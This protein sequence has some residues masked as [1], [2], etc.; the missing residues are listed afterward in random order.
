MV[1]LTLCAN[2]KKHHIAAPREETI[3]TNQLFARRSLSHRKQTNSAPPD[4][5]QRITPR[6]QS[7]PCSPARA[8]LPDARCWCKLD[9]D[10][11]GC[12]AAEKWLGP[13]V[14]NGQSSPS[15]SILVWRQCT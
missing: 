15:S 11:H 13:A 12:C 1:A 3:A 10:E 7:Q 8:L 2:T 6:N 9:A 14:A 5:S 4:D